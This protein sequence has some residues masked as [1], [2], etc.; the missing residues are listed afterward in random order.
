[1]MPWLLIDAGYENAGVKIPTH[2]Q[3]PPL[4]LSVVIQEQC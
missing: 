2:T 3:P 1:M 4:P